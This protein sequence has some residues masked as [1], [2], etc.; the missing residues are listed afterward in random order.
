MYKRKGLDSR[1][2]EYLFMPASIN[3]LCIAIR[4]APGDTKAGLSLASRGDEGC[5]VYIATDS[6]GRAYDSFSGVC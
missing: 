1:A 3:A 5:N 4:V 2:R 6:D